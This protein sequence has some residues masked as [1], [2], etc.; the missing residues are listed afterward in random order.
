MTAS[1]PDQ[2][3]R[4]FGIGF[5]LLGSGEE[6]DHLI[7]NLAMLL[8]SGMGLVQALSAVSQDIRSR[9]LRNLLKKLQD[10]VDAGLSLSSA[11]E[12]TPILPAY[13]VR[14][15]R[16]GEEAGQLEQNLKV[17]ALQQQK[18]RMLR[19]KIKSAMLYP[20]MVLVLAVIIGLTVSWFILPRL[21]VVF[22]NLKLELPLLTRMLIAT[23]N[24]LSHFGIVAV[25]AGIFGIV[26]LVYFVFYFPKTKGFGQG[27]LFLLPASGTLLQEIELTRLG[28]LLG[29][30][31]A[32][33][34]PIVEAVELLIPATNMKLYRAFYATTAASLEDG[35]SFE[36]I[37]ARISKS[38]RLIPVPV[39]QM[40]IS[41]EQSGNL[42]EALMR[43]GQTYEE[44]TDTTAKNL[45]ILLEPIL[46]VIVWLAVVAVA[47]AVILPLY[48]LLG[49]L[50]K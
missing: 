20:V 43:I 25:P 49:G 15:I 50:N 30:L 21:A 24:F 22:S 14:L 28:Y 26:V 48:R 4:S 19:T 31:L 46:L 45:T 42:P 27:L 11:L 40:I 37:F 34:L 36:Q 39:Q 2:A 38:R 3:S 1:A 12:R 29:H 33:G 8:A 17:V 32:A 41:A 10:D 7:E 18:D 47:L 44:K 6:L 9:P 5:K 16:I 23:G 35:D 13:V